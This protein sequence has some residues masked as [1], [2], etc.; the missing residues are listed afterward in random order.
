MALLPGMY[1]APGSISSA[2]QVEKRLQSLCAGGIGSSVVKSMQAC[3]VFCHQHHKNWGGG[4]DQKTIT[5]FYGKTIWPQF[6]HP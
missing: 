6:C 1:E 4:G 5:I 2:T 3:T